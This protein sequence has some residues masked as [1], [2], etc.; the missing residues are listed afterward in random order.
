MI[1][2]LYFSQLWFFSLNKYKSLDLTYETFVVSSM[3]LSMPSQSMLPP[4]GNLWTVLR[5]V[6]SVSFNKLY[7]VASKLTGLHTHLTATIWTSVLLKLRVATNQ[8]DKEFHFLFNFEIENRPQI[9]NSRFL[10]TKVLTCC[11]IREVLCYSRHTRKWFKLLET[12]V[13]VRGVVI[14]ACSSK[15]EENEENIPKKIYLRSKGEGL[16]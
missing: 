11:A 13:W 5:G 9:T 4:V 6:Y 2:M 1:L 16:V 7:F 8:W 3:H 15:H 10:K 14:E 12:L